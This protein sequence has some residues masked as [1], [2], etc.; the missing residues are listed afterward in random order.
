MLRLLLDRTGG[1]AVLASVLVLHGSLLLVNGVVV[2]V[3]AGIVEVGLD[4]L[5]RLSSLAADAR[6]GRLLDL[7]GGGVGGC[8]AAAVVLLGGAAS[9]GGGA[10]VDAELALDLSETNLLNVQG[11]AITCQSLVSLVGG[12]GQGVCMCAR[13]C[14]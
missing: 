10:V 13:A 5:G 2:V 3:V 6:G 11:K 9:G 7:G 12:K 14:A 1:D 8:A 4:G